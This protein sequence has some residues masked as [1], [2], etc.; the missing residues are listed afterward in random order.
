M[1]GLNALVSMG[2]MGLA[3]GLSLGVASKKFAV[4]S[5]PRA[6]AIL[7]VLP[8]ANCGGCGYPGCA[9][10]AAA[11]AEGKAPV[12][13]C[14]VGKA[15]VARQVAKI[16]G[17]EASGEMEPK[18]ARVLCLGS[19]EASPNV[20]EYAGIHDCRAA[21]LSGGGVKGCTYG[22]LGLGSCVSAC[23]FDA[24]YMGADGLPRVLDGACTGCGKCVAACP[25]SLIQLRTKSQSVNVVCRSHDRGPDVKKVCS[26]GCIACGICVKNCPE[27]AISMDGNVAVIDQSKCT[28]CGVCMEKCPV[29][30]IRNM[31]DGVRAECPKADK[32]EATA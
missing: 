16:M 22:C 9:G 23:P 1:N 14:P 28:R 19:H 32:V 25:R 3:F 31:P 13:K 15:A 4:N 6:D 30:C 12:D 11:I 24:M 10:L 17:V 18:Y 8:A 20:A 5:D 2:A 21:M 26:A 29:K 27:K 7:A